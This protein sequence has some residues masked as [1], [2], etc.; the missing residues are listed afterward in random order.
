M[1]G[2]A[3]P[4]VVASGLAYLALMLVLGLWAAT[5]TRNARDFFI[6]GQ[7]PGLFATTLATMAAA[8][9]GFLFVGGP[10]LTYRLGV[11][12]FFI[13]LPISL[14]GVLLCVTVG[15][16]LRRLAGGREIYTVSDVVLARWGSRRAAAWAAAAVLI[17]S[18][19]YLGAQLQ[20]LAVVLDSVFA[21]S[22]LFNS[23]GPVLAL[24]LGVLVVTIY[25]VAGG[26]V[27]G[28][29]TD[30]AQGLLMMLAAAGV[31]RYAL[32]SGGG[33]ESITRRIAST[34]AEGFGPQFLDPLGGPLGAYGGLGFFLLFTVGVL[35]QPQMLHKFFMLD[36]ARKLRWMPLVLGLSQTLVLLLWLGVGLAVPA[37]VVS[38]RLEPLLVAD[39]ATP[40]F[41]LGFAPP[42]LAGLVFAGILAA[43]MSTA[44]SFVNLVAAVLARDLPRLLGRPS[45]RELLWG[46]L[47]SLT[48]PAAAAAVSWLYGDLIAILGTFAFGIFAASL[49]PALAVGL[50]WDR[51]SARAA[52]RSIAAGLTI[53]LALEA[54]AR[55][56]LLPVLPSLPLPAGMPPSAVALVASFAVLFWSIAGD[57]SGALSDR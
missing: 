27:A 31:C 17:G 2:I 8:F 32:A 12:S 49:A 56:T 10:G 6:A 3:Q 20:A 19:A 13:A 52:R 14:T 50:V 53:S 15:R 1:S 42:F 26:M 16:R 34:T 11:G 7:R 45:R 24:G 36:D 55:Q 54:S 23:S 44:D 18:L 46:R 25:S 57:D 28:I 9:S 4:S 39:E 35:G 48:V 37:L 41:L 47:A 22:D 43:V 33:L 21:L 51:V 38:G 30:V 5:R 40:R 29:Y